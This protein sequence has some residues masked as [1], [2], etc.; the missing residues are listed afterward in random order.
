MFFLHEKISSHQF[1]HQSMPNKL[2]SS[3]KSIQF[4]SNS[5]QKLVVEKKIIRSKIK[6]TVLEVLL[7]LTK[8]LKENMKQANFFLNKY[9]NEYLQ[10]TENYFFF[11]F[12]AQLL[13]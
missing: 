1:Q 9:S 2:K 13:N 8:H 7:D 5:P 11:G 3:E 6:Y 12:V 10:K 4:D